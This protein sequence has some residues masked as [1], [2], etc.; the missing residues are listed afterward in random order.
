MPLFIITGAIDSG[1]TT[2]CERILLGHNGTKRE[3]VLLKKVF[4]HDECVGYDA[5]RIGRGQQVAFTRRTDREPKGWDPLERVGP[6]SVSRS[7]KETA[8]NW[9]LEA[10]STGTVG[11]IVD[12]VGPLE[13]AGGGLSDSVSYV[14]NRISRERELFVVVRRSWLDT[15]V[16]YFSIKDYRLICIPFTNGESAHSSSV[17]SA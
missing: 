6:F 13:T 10:Y 16:R 1:K 9:V 4:R 5:F 7:G 8:N 12:E 14:V 11:L 17:R 3:G 15:V 2:Y